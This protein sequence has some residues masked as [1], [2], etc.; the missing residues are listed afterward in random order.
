MDRNIY[1]S[2][3]SH[4][5]VVLG[6]RSMLIIKNPRQIG[7]MQGPGRGIEVDC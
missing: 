4:L 6:S 1:D 3:W 2:T 7:R 5:T